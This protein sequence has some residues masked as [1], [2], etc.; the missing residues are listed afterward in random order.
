MAQH[1]L[2][3]AAARTLCLPHVMRMEEADATL[4]LCL[5]PAR[6]RACVQVVLA[7]CGEGNVRDWCSTL[8]RV[9]RNL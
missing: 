5:R 4:L 1:F 9:Q 2:L 3:S 7:C 8:P 6:A